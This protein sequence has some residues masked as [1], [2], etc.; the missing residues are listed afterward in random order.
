MSKQSNQQNNS[1]TSYKA[2]RVANDRKVGSC[3]GAFKKGANAR[4]GEAY[5]SHGGNGKADPD[6]SFN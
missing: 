6:R 2:R 5:E 4:P 1:E 3:G